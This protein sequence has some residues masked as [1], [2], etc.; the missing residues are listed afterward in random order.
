MSDKDLL[1]KAVET[2]K[3]ATEEKK[4]KLDEAVKKEDSTRQLQT[5]SP[6]RQR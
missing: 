2:Y 6:T 5:A 3:K 4:A 1:Q